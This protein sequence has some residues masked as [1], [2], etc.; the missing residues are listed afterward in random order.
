MPETTA[1][2][3]IARDLV[4]RFGT[5]AQVAALAVPDMA[6]A[7]RIT[8]RVRALREARGERPV[9]RKIGFSNRGLW[10]RYGVDRPMWNHV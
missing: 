4:A 9:G 6:A 10:E 3:A 8:S 2:D 1:E 5:P 7:G